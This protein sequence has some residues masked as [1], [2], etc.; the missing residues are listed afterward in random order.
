MPADASFDAADTSLNVT[1]ISA[2]NAF[3]D[4]HNPVYGIGSGH[5]SDLFNMTGSTL[6]F[7]GAPSSGD[8]AVNVTAP[9][10]NFGTNNHRI[11]DIMVTGTDVNTDPV[12]QDIGSKSVN[13]LVTLTFTAAASDDDA[14]DTLTF[15][16]ASGA[17][18]GASITPAG[19]FSWTPTEQQDGT[20]TITIQVEDGS[21]ATDSD[22]ITVAVGEVNQSPTLNPIGSKSVDELATLTFTATATD[23]DVI[24]GTDDALTFSLASGA[25]TGA[26]I[27]P[28][29]AF[30]WTPTESQDG[31]HDITIQVEDGSG[32]TDSETVTVTV[33]EVNQSP[34]LNP[35][36][37]K[38]VDELA[39]LTFTA[40]A[41]DG[42]VIGGADD[43][44]TFSLASGAPTGA[45]ITPAGAFSWTPTAGQVGTH[46][47]TVVVTDGSGA[48]DSEA[49][50]VTVGGSN[51]NPVLNSIGPKGVNELAT[52]SFTATAT[53]GDNDALTFSL[54][55]GAPTGASITPAGAFSWTPTEQ[56]DGTHTIT[57]QVADDSNA[58]DSETVTVTVNEVNVEPVLASVGNKSVDELVALTFTATATDGDVIGGTDDALT[59]SLASGAPDRR[60]HHAC[61]SVLLDAHRAAG[62]HAHHNHT[63]GGRLRRCRF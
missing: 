33:N 42:D 25:P 13:E 54:A 44:L 16:L 5:D 19:A 12:L 34:M 3:L 57:V 62:R 37:N 23:G 28:A 48:T 26:S 45:S 39:T 52:L 20:H 41:T 38:S 30:S 55:S 63:S 10:G 61:R 47:V 18:T 49:I 15:S 27:T 58:T 21:G 2:Q 46:A 31:T 6:A 7:K 53:D 36:G 43:A 51:Q 40:T 1:T 11:L 29:G 24:G 17:P 4:G 32:A 56:Q 59:F 8:Y 14:G 60:L 9:G 50:T 35:I 22:T